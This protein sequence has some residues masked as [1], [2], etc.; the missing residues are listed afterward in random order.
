MDG[1]LSNVPKYIITIGASAGGLIS[2]IEL[3]AQL[4]EDIDAAIF[5]VLHLPH[6]SNTDV[7]TFRIKNNT[8]LICKMAEHEEIIQR[9]YIYL[10][11]PDRHLMVK[12][13]HILLGQGAPENRWR[14][15]IDVLFRSAAVNYG[16]RTIGVI[17]SGL[18][19][20]GATGM[21][22]IKQAGGTCIVQD[23]A[24][25]QY[26]DMPQAVLNHIEAD[27]CVSLTA[28][29]AILSEKTRNGHPRNAPLPEHLIKEAQIAERVA[30]GIKNVHELGGERS[31]YSCPDCGGA[32]YEMVDEN[33][34]RFRCHT[35][36]AYNSNDL[37]LRQ[38][39]EL[40]N[41]LWTALRML[42]ER[43]DLM[44]KMVKEESRKGWIKAAEMKLERIQELEEH[45]DRL[46]TILFK[47]QGKD[48][49]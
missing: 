41:T 17:L 11:D 18:M 31:D 13:D 14:P 42:E 46:K 16:S 37:Y 7:L 24:E 23:P 12:D 4:K 6:I 44:K 30:L 45:T 5:I 1:N 39:E 26:P 29:G 3:C 38:T 27:Y 10:A 21:M 36:H 19:Q 43:K 2:V 32:L 28:I 15:S 49:K 22:A 35:G 9:G 40:E 33:M 20:D 25:A 48:S 34:I 47:T 8:P